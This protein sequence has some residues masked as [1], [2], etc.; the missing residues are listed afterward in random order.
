MYV[1]TSLSF[2][3]FKKSLCLK[4]FKRNAM[5][6]K[7]VKTEGVKVKLKEYLVSANS[8]KKSFSSLLYFEITIERIFVVL[9]E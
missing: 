8:I 3:K 5:V 7:Q 4:G 1:G 2:F 6:W 9:R